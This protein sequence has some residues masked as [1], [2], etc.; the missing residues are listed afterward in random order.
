MSELRS[1][2]VGATQEIKR[3]RDDGSKFS[4]SL[5]SLEQE[6]LDLLHELGTCPLC[7]SST[8]EVGHAV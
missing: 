4:A 6:R 1:Q 8:E 5:Q 2:Y 7:G 3:W